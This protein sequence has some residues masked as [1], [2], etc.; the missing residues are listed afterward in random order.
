M[1]KYYFI[2]LIVLGVLAV[3]VGVR[4]KVLHKEYADTAMAVALF[5]EIIISAIL[6]L[7]FFIWFKK[8]GK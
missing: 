1:K 8:R 2:V 5:F 3:I 6:I 4:A 7:L